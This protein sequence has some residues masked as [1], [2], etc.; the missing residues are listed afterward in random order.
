[1]T[2]S[3]FAANNGGGVSIDE[4]A[5]GDDHGDTHGQDKD[6][7]YAA[8]DGDPDMARLRRRDVGTFS[9]SS[10]TKL[11][12]KSASVRSPKALGGCLKSVSGSGSGTVGGS[13]GGGGVNRMLSS[14]V[15]SSALSF[16]RYASNH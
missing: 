2:S 7:D 4:N 16:D 6:V 8:P 10:T 15:S 14:S 11:P 3:G 13:G 12:L 1:M 5:D 9:S